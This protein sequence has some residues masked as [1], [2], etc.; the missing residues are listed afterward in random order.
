MV[1][2]GEAVTTT[3][4]DGEAAWY[5]W[6][7]DQVQLLCE[8]HVHDLDDPTPE[9]RAAIRAQVLAGVDRFLGPMPEGPA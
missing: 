4:A 7:A 8:A 5:G 9:G 2:E 6:L 3:P 1:L